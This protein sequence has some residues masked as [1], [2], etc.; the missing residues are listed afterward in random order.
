MQK[1]CTSAFQGDCPERWI[2][3]LLWRKVICAGGPALPAAELRS[4]SSLGLEVVFATMGGGRR[5]EEV[6]SCSTWDRNDSQ[7]TFVIA[8]TEHLPCP[9][10]MSR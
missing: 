2:F 4:A 3:E 10:C 7:L 8:V 6:N 9:G 1:P 5:K